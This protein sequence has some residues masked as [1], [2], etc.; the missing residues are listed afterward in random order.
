MKR[1]QIKGFPKSSLPYAEIPGS[2][3]VVNKHLSCC[4][5][6][7]SL[8]LMFVLTCEVVSV[9]KGNNVQMPPGVHKNTCPKVSFQNRWESLWGFSVSPGFAMRGSRSGGS[10]LERC[11]NKFIKKFYAFKKSRKKDEYMWRRV[12]KS[13]LGYQWL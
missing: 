12:C 9:S 3:L 8:L 13:P 7:F 4:L 1:T 11:E 2:Q 5:I 10:T 6:F